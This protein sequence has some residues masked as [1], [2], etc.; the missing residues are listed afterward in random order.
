[1]HCTVCVCVYYTLTH[2]E[3]DTQYFGEGVTD[4]QLHVVASGGLDRMSTEPDPCVR[5]DQDRKHWVYLHRHRYAMCMCL[6]FWRIV[7]FFLL[8]LGSV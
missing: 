7:F 1:M 8:L 6:L 3:L 5:F 4:E 2:A